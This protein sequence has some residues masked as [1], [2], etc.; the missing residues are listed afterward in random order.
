MSGIEADAWRH[1]PEAFEIPRLP[2]TPAAPG[3]LITGYQFSTNALTHN[4]HERR[5]A[6]LVRASYAKE[7]SF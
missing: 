7:V 1:N 4:S 2:A 6:A 5:P 3:G